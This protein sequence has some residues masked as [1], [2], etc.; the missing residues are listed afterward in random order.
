[1]TPI[2]IDG[3]RIGE[4]S[5]RFDEDVRSDEEQENGVRQRGEDL[6]PVQPVGALRSVSGSIGGNDGGERH[7]QSQRVGAHVPRVGQQRERIGRERGNDLD[8]QKAQDE[9][10]GDRQVLAIAGASPLRGEIV[11]GHSRN[12]PRRRRE[13]A[14]SRPRCA[15]PR[16]G[17]R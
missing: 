9:D 10:E 14:L 8:D 5:G 16:A 4:A 6:E 15:P 11:V 7:R 1:M 2:S 3:L 13:A 17:G 12:V